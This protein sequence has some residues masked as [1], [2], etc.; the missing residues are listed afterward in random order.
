MRIRIVEEDTLML[1]TFE[2]QINNVLE[3]L[4][5]ETTT[6]REVK[7]L[8]EHKVIIIYTINKFI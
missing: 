1:S 6:I 7:A 5:N 3:E 2:E 4:D 8:S